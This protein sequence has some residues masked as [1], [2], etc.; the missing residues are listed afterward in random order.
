[1]HSV[2]EMTPEERSGLV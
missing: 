2:C 1:M